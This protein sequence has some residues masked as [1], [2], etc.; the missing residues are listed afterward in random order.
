MS[1][2]EAVIGTKR[3]RDD[4]EV[5]EVIIR[6]EGPVDQS[7]AMIIKLSEPEKDEECIIT[8]E[9]MASYKLEFLESD[10]S[11]FLDQPEILK[12]Q[13]PC[14]HSFHVLAIF[15][16]FA[17]NSMSCPCCREGSE[18]VMDLA[19][20]PDHLRKQFTVQIEKQKKTEAQESLA[21][22]MTTIAHIL[23]QEVN[24]NIGDFFINHRVF[25]TVYFYETMDSIRPFLI[26]ELP[27]Y[28]I[29][30]RGP[31]RFES[32]GSS[33]RH[34]HSNLQMV[35]IESKAME[36]VIGTRSIFDGVMALYRTHKFKFLS[37][38]KQRVDGVI[39]M[40]GS[41][42]ILELSNIFDKPKLEG[43]VW[44]I[45]KPT[46]TRLLVLGTFSNM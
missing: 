39:P 40:E 11:F 14:G 6:T 4:T 30:N 2:V 21:D 29:E 18:S 33:I 12:A 44:E 32:L 13:L 46:F 45:T 35:G 20:V 42:L 34:V 16:H 9:K 7:D 3:P 19:C 8:M 24:Y 41:N 43:I 37:T 10:V 26:S 22:N 38:K 36:M 28:C 17:R 23:E 25:L 15:Y 1:I 5:Q 31:L 27:L